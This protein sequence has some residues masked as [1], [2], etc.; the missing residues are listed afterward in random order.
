[1]PLSSESIIALVAFLFTVPP[2]LLMI[3]KICHKR[4]RAPAIVGAILPRH[5]ASHQHKNNYLPSYR[6]TRW[7]ATSSIRVES[8]VVTGEPFCKHH[9]PADKG[10]S[11]CG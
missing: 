1:M 6:L 2:S 10:C 11:M 4:S 8:V 9:K 5:S 7:S 3:W